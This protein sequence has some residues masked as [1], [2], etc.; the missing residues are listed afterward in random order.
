MAQPIQQQER[1]AARGSW[2]TVE[3]AFNAL[4][5]LPARAFFLTLSDGDRRK[6]MALF[7]RLAEFGRISHIEKFKALGKAGLGLWEFKSHQIRFIGDFREGKRFLVA[8]GLWKK[9]DNLDRADIEHAARV[10]RE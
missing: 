1:V 2:G 10:L 8:H 9:K 4:R 7:Q 5:E 3:W 6:V